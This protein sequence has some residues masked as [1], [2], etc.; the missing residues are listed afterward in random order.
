MAKI[1]LDQS[2]G[3]TSLSGAISRHRRPD[4]TVL[5]TFCT[6]KGRMY[7]RVY[8]R[9]TPLSDRE[10]ESRCRFSLMSREVTQRINN[11][12]HRPKSEIW[13]EVKASWQARNL[14]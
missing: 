12:D 3:I 5:V 13:K 10:I 2:L 11:G 9:T 14:V 4:G 7:M 6:K 8:K 1:E